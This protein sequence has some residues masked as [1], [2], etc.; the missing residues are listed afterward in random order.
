MS[1]LD[2]M[3]LFVRVADLGSFAAAATQ[4]GVARSVVTRQIAGLEAD[5]GTKLM[6][7]T[8]RR[9]TLTSAGQ[10]YLDHCRDILARVE[11]AEAEVMEAKGVPRGPVRLGLPLDFGLDRLLPIL[12]S[13]SQRYPEVELVMDFTDRQ[14]NLIKEGYDLAIRITT[15]LQP[16]DVVR[17]LG[18]SHLLTVAAPAYLQIHGTPKHPEDL[19]QHAC[20][21]Y[22]Q[23]LSRTPWVYSLA[24]KVENFYIP[25]KLIANNGDALCRAALQGLGITFQPD[26]IVAEALATGEL[27]TL[28]DEYTPPPFGIYALLPSNRYMPFRVRLLLETLAAGLG[29]VAE[30]NEQGAL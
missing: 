9:L 6:V 22:S 1:R 23:E 2:A 27:V 12:L 16:G 15:R 14:I 5:L 29:G 13:F 8:T 3:Q 18:E 30:T 21:G 4:M 7:R 17:K 26:F 19:Q 28:L 20:L 11:M 24:G 10:R 25:F